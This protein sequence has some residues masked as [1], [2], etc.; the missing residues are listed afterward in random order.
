MPFENGAYTVNWM[1]SNNVPVA[2]GESAYNLS[3]G[4]YLVEITDSFLCGPVID[5]I[6]I[7]QPS[8]FYLDVSNI[9]DNELE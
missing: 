5:T 7:T 9:K 8:Q 1:D 3:A 4:T 2:N 6:I